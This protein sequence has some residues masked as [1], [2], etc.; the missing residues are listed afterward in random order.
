MWDYK[1]PEYTFLYDPMEMQKNWNQTLVT[2]FNFINASLYAANIKPSKIINVPELFRELIESLEYYTK[3]TETTGKVSS[4]NINFVDEY[5]KGY[6]DVQG[7]PLAIKNYYKE[8]I[9]YDERLERRIRK[10]NG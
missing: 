7:V 3:I 2:Q 4:Y 5:T 6:V 9:S 8:D 10:Q 1:Y